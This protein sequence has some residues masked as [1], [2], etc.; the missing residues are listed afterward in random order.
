MQ[1]TFALP[2]APTVKRSALYG[3]LSAR[4]VSFLVDTTL[5]VF[6]YTFLL[7]GLSA[8]PE[9][10][11]TWDKMAVDGINLWELVEVGKAIFLNPYFPII[12]WAYY[13]LLESSQKQATIG[14]F[15]LGLRVTDLRGKPITFV[16]ANLRYFC[17][18]LSLVPLGLGF[19]LMVNSRRS[20]MLHDYFARALV[21]NE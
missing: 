8:V 19:L 11:Q 20:Q 2:N 6:S 15:T 7:Y 5:I 1:T 17:K 4:L 14:K 16:Q 13:T 10:L 3:T 12:H 21:V 18:L 9:H